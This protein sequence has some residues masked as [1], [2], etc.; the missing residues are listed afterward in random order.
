MKIRISRNGQNYGPYAREKVEQY[1]Q[2][3]DLL[4]RDLA[5]SP[6]L[7]AWIP[8]EELLELLGTGAKTEEAGEDADQAGTTEGEEAS[9]DEA[10]ETGE[11]AEETEPED[12]ENVDEAVTP[13]DLEDQE[14]AADVPAAGDDDEDPGEGEE[15]GEEYSDEVEAIA[16]PDG[17]CPEEIRILDEMVADCREFRELNQHLEDFNIW[18]T[19]QMIENEGSHEKTLYWLLNRRKSHNLGDLF[20]RRW[21]IRILREEEHS[22]RGQL[23]PINLE[24]ARIKR[25]KISRQK[26][27]VPGIQDKKFKKLDLFLEISTNDEGENDQGKRG[28][29]VEEWVLL[30]EMKVKSGLG[31]KQLEEY[32]TWVEREY[33]D[34]KRLLVLLYDEERP[35]DVP[36]GENKH[37][38]QTSFT[39]VRQVLMEIVEEFGSRIPDRERDF[40]DQYLEVLPPLYPKDSSKKS[41]ALTHAIYGKYWKGIEYAKTAYDAPGATTYWG[42]HAKRLYVHHKKAFELIL[43]QQSAEKFLQKELTN[44]LEDMFEG[45]ESGRMLAGKTKLEL[46]ELMDHWGV[47]N[48]NCHVCMQLYNSN[49]AYRLRIWVH[50]DT[51]TNPQ[52]QARAAARAALITNFFGSI[53][54]NYGGRHG[55]NEKKGRIYNKPLE[56]GNANLEQDLFVRAKRIFQEFERIWKDDEDFQIGLKAIENHLKGRF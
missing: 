48:P 16:R 52:A 45:K 35:P 18:K 13:E 33:P 30:V 44:L 47:S 36:E 50:S 31:T 56:S 7:A 3:N 42:R 43:K 46:L 25:L 9:G 10:E 37:W 53:P 51:S 20:L 27:V 34:H 19:L 21:L 39:E 49:N 23:N 5:W 22:E 26:V 54:K 41:E 8:L 32:R 40:I 17:A 12:G 6:G 1:L 24:Y 38:I 2:T 14:R 15:E 29:L 4:P 11:Q 28:L 55:V